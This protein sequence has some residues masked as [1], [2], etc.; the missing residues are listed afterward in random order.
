M[1]AELNAVTVFCE[2]MRAEASGSE[3]LVG[4]WPDNLN[5]PA[6][7]FTIPKLCIY[8]RIAVG[9]DYPHR[10]LSVTMTTPDR[11]EHALG[12]IDAAL[13]TKSLEDARFHGAPMTTI[14]MRAVASPFNVLKPGRVEIYVKAH[15]KKV[16]TASLNIGLAPSE[17]NAS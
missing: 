7:P 15:R 6:F 4:I 12:T 14:I 8:T 10:N 5:L 13:F 1:S 2:D 11:Q 3:T 17:P 9:I 16:L